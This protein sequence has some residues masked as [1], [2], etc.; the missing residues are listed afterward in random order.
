[1][2][3][4]GSRCCDEQFGKSE[5]EH[6]QCAAKDGV[7]SVRENSQQAGLDAV[8]VTSARLPGCDGGKALAKEGGGRG[9]CGGGAGGGGRAQAYTVPTARAES[10]APRQRQGSAGQPAATPEQG[11]ESTWALGPDD[12][13][14]YRPLGSQSEPFT[15]VTLS[16]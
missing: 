2:G 15:R 13:S 9:D 12:F 14:D 16:L 11:F 4:A 8:V 5:V 7:S 6:V 10:A 1:M 3:Q